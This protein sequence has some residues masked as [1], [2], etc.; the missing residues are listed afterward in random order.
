MEIK[1]TK[2]IFDG[3]E[4]AIT[5]ANVKN[6]MVKRMAVASPIEDGYLAMAHILWPDGTESIISEEDVDPERALINDGPS[7][8]IC[9]STDP[10]EINAALALNL[11]IAY[12]NYY[13]DVEAIEEKIKRE[14]EQSLRELGERMR[15]SEGNFK[16]DPKWDD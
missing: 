11:S 12:Q 14:R 9:E 16:T 13:R 15:K 2:G 8:V 6:P 3:M 4:G 10:E 7:M 5:M 1:K